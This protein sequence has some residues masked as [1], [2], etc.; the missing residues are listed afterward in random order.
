M[1]RN[2]LAIILSVCLVTVG[3]IG[4]ADSKTRKPTTAVKNLGKQIE[5]VSKKGSKISSKAARGRLGFIIPFTATT[6][7]YYIYAQQ[8]RTCRIVQASYEYEAWVQD[9]SGARV[10]A[11]IQLHFWRRVG[12]IGG[13]THSCENTTWCPFTD[14][15]Y[16]TD[17]CTRS[18]FRACATVGGASGCT[19]DSVLD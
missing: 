12:P 19:E 15:Q 17:A 16:G 4:N 5:Q 9:D 18:V 1:N 11:N 6:Q 8:K 3:G 14:N 7:N 13:Y 10:P 2:F